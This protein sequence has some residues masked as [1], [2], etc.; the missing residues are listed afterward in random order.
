M[1]EF[2][3]IGNDIVKNMSH[4]I[5]MKQLKLGKGIDFCALSEY[6]TRELENFSAGINFKEA[7]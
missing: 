2:R 3:H 7:E 1:R 5:Q 6:T 4:V